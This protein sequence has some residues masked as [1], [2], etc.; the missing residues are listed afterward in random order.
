MLWRE[1][2][3]GN[4]SRLAQLLLHKLIYYCFFQLIFS[5]SFFLESV[6][7]FEIQRPLSLEVSLDYT[8]E[9]SGFLFPDR[10]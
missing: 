2:S 4:H 10:Q 8:R 9:G 7:Y 6:Q 5:L 3:V 1:F